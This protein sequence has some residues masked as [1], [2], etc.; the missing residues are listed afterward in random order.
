[1]NLMKVYYSQELIVRNDETFQAQNNRF[2]IKIT[3]D[4]HGKVKYY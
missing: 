1:M 4:S 3:E 2:K